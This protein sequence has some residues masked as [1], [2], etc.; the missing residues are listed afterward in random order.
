[1]NKTMKAAVSTLACLA[2]GCADTVK[3]SRGRY[4]RV[5]DRE[6]VS[7][8]PAGE[9]GALDYRVANHRLLLQVS[10]HNLCE[11]ETRESYQIV[12]RMDHSAQNGWWVVPLLGLISTTAGALV[13]ENAHS[14]PTQ[15]LDSDGKPNNPRQDS[16]AISGI[17]LS[18]GLLGMMDVPLVGGRDVVREKGVRTV[19]ESVTC[20]SRAYVGP[21]TVIRAGRST[22]AQT[23]QSGRA[24]VAMTPLAGG[25]SAAPVSVAIKEFDLLRTLQL[26]PDELVELGID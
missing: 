25:D 20:G 14:Q 7:S 24:S 17:L 8:R 3:Y 19:P 9:E 11:R 23:D 16:Y 5:Y 10:R 6:V 12:E 22:Q 13:L 2:C 4:E 15:G 26:T 21:V 1:V 18:L